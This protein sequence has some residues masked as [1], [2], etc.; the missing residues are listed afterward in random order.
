MRVTQSMYYKTMN[1]NS[2]NVTKGLFDV[3]KQISSGQKIQYAYEGSE[4]FINTLRLDDEVATHTQVKNSASSAF[5]FSTQTDTVLGDFTKTLDSFKTKLISAA[6]V[7]ANSDNSLDAIAKEL[8]SM[9]NHLINLSN[10]SVNGSFL[11]SGSATDTKPISQDGSYN[12]NDADL[13]AFFGADANQK[14]NISG[15]QLFLG[16]ESRINRTI[17]TN[18]A[19]KD[20]RTGQIANEDNTLGDITNNSNDQT[21]YLRGRNSDGSS[22]K[23][24][25]TLNSTASI[26]NLLQSVENSFL[27]NSVNVSLDQGGN[28]VIEDKRS[29]SSKLDFQLVA[30]ESIEDDIDNLVPSIEFNKSALTSN[31][32]VTGS[33]SAIYDRVF[34]S[35]DGA[36]LSSNVSQTLNSD[37]SFA[38]DST[39]LSEV[40]SSLS[41][42]LDIEGK[43]LDGSTFNINV[44]LGSP[45]S[46]SGDYNYNINNGDGVDTNGADVTYRQFLDV[47]NVA[48]NN[49]DPSTAPVVPPAQ[50]S[51][52]SAIQES[53]KFSEVELS[54]DGKISFR[55]L[56]NNPTLADISIADSNSDDFSNTNGAI[57][58]FQTN[59]ALT[60]RDPKTDFFARIEEAIV[61]VES[62]NAYPDGNGDNARNGGIQNAIQIIDDLSEH[63]FRTQSQTGAQ[64]NAID[65]Q[66]QRTDTL[67]VTTQTLRSEF[68]DT[69]IAD[70]VLRLN[71]LTLNYQA[72]MSTISRVAQLSLVNYL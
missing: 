43:R 7:G 16:E 59:N 21:F 50:N 38:V 40:F 34:F 42:S 53:N 48:I 66:I 22:I 2:N 57:A 24:R 68:V 65:S 35:K 29:G 9:K 14:Y 20:S 54:A 45:A 30:G 3:N 5:K 67:I 19:L 71:Q 49:Q 63:V 27:P 18:I 33:E 60:I 26:K 70:S 6:N 13:K 39:K 47:I 61:A 69:D 37:N 36:T 52:Q 51:Y 12:G 62:H 25:F 15:S 41:S 64:S 55:D 46:V 11:F 23:E 72:M 8:R 28:I 58:T 4:T 1:S 44:T 32:S 10:T 17:T 31:S 56:N